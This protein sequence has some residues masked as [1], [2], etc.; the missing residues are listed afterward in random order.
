[1]QCS[2]GD[3]QFASADALACSAFAGGVAGVA[4]GAGG[5]TDTMGLEVFTVAVQQPNATVCD[6]DPSFVTNAPRSV[7]WMSLRV[8]DGSYGPY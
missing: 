1:M 8:P 7:V 4:R 5:S 3:L 6:T 2:A